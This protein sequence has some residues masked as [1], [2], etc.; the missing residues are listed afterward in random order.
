MPFSNKLILIKMIWNNSRI[1]NNFFVFFLFILILFGCDNQEV[2]RA[3]PVQKIAKKEQIISKVYVLKNEK[4]TLLFT[5]TSKRNYNLQNELLS[6]NDELFYDF[7]T[8]KTNGF[9]RLKNIYI[10]QKNDTNIQ[11]NYVYNY[12]NDKIEIKQRINGEDRICIEIVEDTKQNIIQQTYFDENNP[13]EKIIENLFIYKADNLKEKRQILYRKNSLKTRTST[14]FEYNK[15]GNI[16]KKVKLHTKDDTNVGLNP[17]IYGQLDTLQT[18]QKHYIYNQKQQL[19]RLK[20]S[21]TMPQ[22]A[23]IEDFIFLEKNFEYNTKGN[24]TQV[25]TCCMK[26]YK[27]LYFKDTLTQNITTYEYF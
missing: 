3:I 10:T 16:T 13:S 4:M 8:L 1:K 20:V 5:D 27:L 12:L 7:D 9:K 25:R 6:E 23:D 24:C 11:K 17:F 26:S 15:S 2:V 22:S 18:Q 19:I 14:F 21:K